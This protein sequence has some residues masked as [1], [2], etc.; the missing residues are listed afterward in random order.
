MYFAP[1][2][3]LLPTVVGNLCCKCRASAHLGGR[4]PHS[5]PLGTSD[6]VALASHVCS[7]ASQGRFGLEQ[8]RARLQTY[9]STIWKE[10]VA[11]V[12]EAYGSGSGVKLSK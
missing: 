10:Q 1:A 8:V 2:D 11:H 12:T 4:L 5:H 7:N 6:L 9:P 3:H